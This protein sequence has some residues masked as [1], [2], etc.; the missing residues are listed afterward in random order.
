MPDYNLDTSQDAYGH[1]QPLLGQQ[2]V[3]AATGTAAGTIV[4]GTIGSGSPTIINAI[5]M[6]GAF[7]ITGTAAAGVLATV[8]FYNGLPGVPKSVDISIGLNAGTGGG[9]AGFGLVAA[10]L[11]SLVINAATL[12]AAVYYVSYLIIC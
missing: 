12:T 4:T 3:A 8:Y 2:L 10:N 11:N 1:I 7:T 9:I 6:A 5:D